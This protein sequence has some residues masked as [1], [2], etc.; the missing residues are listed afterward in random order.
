MYLPVLIFVKAFN[1]LRVKIFHRS[2]DAETIR[3]WQKG[4]WLEGWADK[5]GGLR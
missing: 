1:F 3:A 4:L 5:L 2:W